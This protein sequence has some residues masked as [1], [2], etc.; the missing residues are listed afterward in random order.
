MGKTYN[1]YMAKL[2]TKKTG[3]RVVITGLI[4]TAI[5]FSALMFNAFN[6]YGKASSCINRSGSCNLSGNEIVSHLGIV[7]FF[8]GL[9][10]TGLGIMVFAAGSKHQNP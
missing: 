2:A 9:V 5:A 4:T 7:A 6:T 10:L 1:S 8:F 3:L